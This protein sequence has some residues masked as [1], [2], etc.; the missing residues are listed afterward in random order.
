MLVG[1]GL[2]VDDATDALLSA[3]FGSTR[4][5]GGIGFGSGSAATPAEEG[6]IVRANKPVVV[7]ADALTW[8]S[9]QDQWWKRVPAELLVLTPHPGEMAKLRGVE[10]GHVVD[11]PIGIARAAAT[12]WGQTVLLKGGTAVVASPDG[13]TTSIESSPALASAGS[14]DVLGGS[15]AAFLAQGLGPR[16]A[17]L[18]ASY[19]GV[20]AAKRAAV[21][22]GTLGV[23][24][25][26]LPLALAET[27]AEL[28]KLE[29]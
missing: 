15:V 8:L 27:I 18:L 17:A 23:I 6:T 3:L 4:S 21:R 20:R 11:D 12:D 7:D 5:R 26:D 25:G 24:A 9:N 14:G 22:F 16:D 10:V 28:E 19:L 29:N 1:P 13:S 2:G